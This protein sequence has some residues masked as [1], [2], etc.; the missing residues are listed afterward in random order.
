MGKS[1][2]Y[3][4]RQA[5][6]YTRRKLRKRLAAMRLPCALCGL[7]I[8]YEL[9]TYV[10]PKDGKTK[11]HPMRFEVDEIVPIARGGDPFDWSNLQPAHRICNQKRGKMT[12]AQWNRKK[13]ER[14]IASEAARTRCE[15][16]DDEIR[17]SRQW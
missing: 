16:A 6:G 10:D 9:S 11:P 13:S 1:V 17:P 15:A 14:K 7:P 8:D 2:E 12:M 4:P 5:R 3:D